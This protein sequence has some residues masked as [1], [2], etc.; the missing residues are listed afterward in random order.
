[1]M[2]TASDPKK[3]ECPARSDGTRYVLLTQCLQNDFFLNRECQIYLGDEAA[4]AMLIGNTTEVVPKPTNGRLSIPADALSRGP[5]GSFLGAV[6]DRRRKGED[7]DGRLYVINIRDWHEPGP[8]Y[9]V[10]RRA[11]GSHCEKG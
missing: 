8:S 7:G 11:Y 3:P 1:M 4:L 2:V 5:L 6:I 9:D 10:E